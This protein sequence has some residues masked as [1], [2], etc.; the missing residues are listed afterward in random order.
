MIIDA[1]LY[2][3]EADIADIR[4]NELKDTVDKFIVVS[5]TTTLT[6]NPNP[7]MFPLHLFEL[8]DIEFLRFDIPPDLFR[9]PA[10]Y[11]LRD[12]LKDVLKR[13]FSR[14]DIV[15]VTDGD[16]IPRA[17][18]LKDID[19]SYQLE[20]DQYYYNFNTYMR[21]T[22]YVYTSRIGDLGSMYAMRNHPQPWTPIVD[23]GAWEF[24]FFGDPEFIANKIRNYSHDD[25]D[26]PEYTGLEQIQK[27]IDEGRD[28]VDRPIY[29]E[30]AGPLPEYVHTLDKYWR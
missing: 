8:A 7:N 22:N 17:S 4:I 21:R 25:L 29:G 19:G 12:Q 5:G 24:S 30:P 27:R 3:N 10:E 6:G 28:I 2:Y 20:A 16:E 15:A 23:A 11:W 18:I 9:F 13:R 1:H 14:D 26:V